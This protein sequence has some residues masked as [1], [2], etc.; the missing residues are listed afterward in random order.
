MQVY[1]TYHGSKNPVFDI[2]IVTYNAKDKLRRCLES[3]KKYTNGLRYAL[4]VVN[5]CSS[6]GTLI[7]LKNY[8]HKK[9]KV[10]NTNKNLG[11]CGGANL[12]LR[13]TSNKFIVL[14]DDDAEV[15]KDWLTKLYKQMRNKTKV[16]IVGCKM[17]FL[18]NRIEFSEYRVNPLFLV[19]SG[20]VDIGQ[21]DYIRECDAL[22]GTCWLMRRELIKK[23]GYFDERFFPCQAEDIDYCLRA[24]LAGYKIIYN[25]KVKVIHHNLFRDGGRFRKNNQKFLRK[26]R[27]I[28]PKFPLKDSH[29]V[30]KYIACGVNY[31]EKKSFNQALMEFKKAERIDRRFSEPLYIGMA[32]EG[33]GKYNE[34]IQEVRKVLNLNPT[35]F[36]ARDILVP[37]YKKLGLLKET[38]REAA[39]ALSLFPSYRNKYFRKHA[40]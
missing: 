3:V 34:A 28:L 31:L 8:N 26:W 33:L 4:T 27:R 29:I 16:G 9:V 36:L 17:V 1:E 18:N 40:I 39:K 2:I 21:R 11:F 13:N 14:L 10:V 37:I 22:V 32:L 35:N 30:D 5:N 12:A 23:V 38:K 25:G 20:E 15:T 19:G 7:F 24:R 6:D